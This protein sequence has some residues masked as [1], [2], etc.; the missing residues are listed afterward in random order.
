MSK[1]LKILVVAG[2][3]VSVAAIL[4]WK[5]RDKE[6]RASSGLTTAAVAAVPSEPG[7]PRLVDL[8]A[9][10]CVPCKMMA[11][12]LEELKEQYK[13]T[14]DVVFL[15][16]WKNPDAGAQY[17]IKLIPTQI[18]Y[19]ASGKELFRHEGFFSKDDILA[20]W[21]EFGVTLSASGAATPAFERLTPAKP[22]DRPRRA[23]AI[24]ATGTSI[25]GPSSPF[26]PTK[27]RSEC[28]VF[29]VISSCIRV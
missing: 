21:K 7:L 11:P 22:D 10:K 28:A 25:P 29:T 1:A 6:E 9:D 19:D 5:Q 24:C 15:D 16:V 8:G 23:F 4:V 27:A 12:I 3:I 17:G 14:F 20:K 2:L 26:R 18:F 13:G